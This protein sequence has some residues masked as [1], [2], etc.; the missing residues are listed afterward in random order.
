M[1]RGSLLRF[2]QPFREHQLGQRPVLGNHG[3]NVRTS[4]LV[5]FGCHVIDIPR[6][7]RLLL[8][9]EFEQV[10]GEDGNL[11][12]VQGIGLHLGRKT[13][14]GTVMRSDEVNETSVHPW[15]NESWF[16]SE[17]D[18]LE[19]LMIKGGKTAGGK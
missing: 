18:A 4:G 16:D 5:D 12:L 11:G 1:S 2:R 15:K 3:R 14:V 6:R 8:F 19:Y 17:T 7:E 13:L 9:G 10:L